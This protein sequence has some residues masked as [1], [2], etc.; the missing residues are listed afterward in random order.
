MMLSIF[1]STGR[2]GTTGF[3]SHEQRRLHYSCTLMFAVTIQRTDAAEAV[4]V[5]FQ[6]DLG[7]PDPVQGSLQNSL[8][9]WDLQHLLGLLRA[10]PEHGRKR[11]ASIQPYR[12]GDQI[13]LTCRLC[14][15]FHSY[16]SFQPLQ[17]C[18]ATSKVATMCALGN[19][20]IFC[21]P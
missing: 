4:A 21:P 3:F 10:F 12:C 7:K 16:V 1:Y 5:W 19:S 9:P 18:V 14:D 2:H 11:E 6:S 15:S 13:W 17:T 8:H 20:I